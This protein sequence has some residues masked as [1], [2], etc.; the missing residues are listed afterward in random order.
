MS[1][2]NY[3]RDMAIERGKII[4]KVEAERDEARAAIRRAQAAIRNG[5]ITAG[6]VALAI[7]SIG[8]S[9][10]PSMLDERDAARAE[11]A[12]L[13]AR[14]ADAERA[15][16]DAEWELSNMRAAHDSACR[17]VADMHA[18]AVGAERSG[19]IRGVVEDVADVRAHLDGMR[20]KFRRLA[21]EISTGWEPLEQEGGLVYTAYKNA[22]KEAA[23]RINVILEEES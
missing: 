11:V 16:A 5:A 19:P 12:A 18:A 1:Y 21:A 14:L 22:F 17:T 6:A 3:Y 23:R 10:Q 13:R 7:V 20:D 4:Q 15:Q 8:D 2:D 9:D